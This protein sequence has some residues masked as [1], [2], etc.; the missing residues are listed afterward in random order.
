M[1][2]NQEFRSAFQRIAQHKFLGQ[3]ALH[4]PY[5]DIVVGTLDIE[6]VVLG[7][8]ELQFATLIVER[9]KSPCGG[10]TLLHGLVVVVLNLAQAAVTVLKSEGGNADNIGY[11]QD[12]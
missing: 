10:R 4:I 12:E 2:I 11:E 1:S 9:D 8:G 7:N 6:Q 3:V 5:M